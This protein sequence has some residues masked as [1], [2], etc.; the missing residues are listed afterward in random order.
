MDSHTNSLGHFRLVGFKSASFDLANFE[1]AG[2]DF[3]LVSFGLASFDLVSFS[4][5]GFRVA[6]FGVVGF[7]MAGLQAVPSN[8]KDLRLHFGFVTESQ[9]IFAIQ[10]PSMFF[11]S[12]LLVLRSLMYQFCAQSARK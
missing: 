11:Y 7:V 2:F 3:D 6:S 1:L 10:F 8:S 12:S 5:A 9:V 4:L